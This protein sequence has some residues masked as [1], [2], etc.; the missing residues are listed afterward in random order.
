M[1]AASISSAMG[2]PADRSIGAV[3][4]P[5]SPL[6]QLIGSQRVG[7]FET[8]SSVAAA[9]RKRRC[10]SCRRLSSSARMWSAT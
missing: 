7:Y 1:S 3:S 4:A 8:G 2:E 5:P 10:R 9:R 6:P